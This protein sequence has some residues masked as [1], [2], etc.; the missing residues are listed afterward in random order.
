MIVITHV[1]NVTGTVFDIKSIGAIAKEK[2]LTFFVDAAQSAG[3]LDIDVQ[4][5]NIDLLAFTAHKYM[6]CPQGLGGLYVRDGIQVRPLMLGGGAANSLELHPDL[7]MPETTE[8]GTVN[9]PGIVAMGSAVDYLRANKEAIQK[10][11]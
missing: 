4:R 9:M 2:G 5:D 11:E 10:K 1:S 7:D 8:A 6:F 3:V